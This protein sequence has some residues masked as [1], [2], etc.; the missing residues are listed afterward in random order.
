MY[1]YM[2]EGKAIAEMFGRIAPRYDLANRL[3]SGGV[4]TYW[5]WRMVRL[6]KKIQP[7]RVIDL[8]TGSGDVA[9]ALRK[10][11]GRN[12]NIIGLDFCPEM[13]EQAA[14]KQAHLPDSQKITFT[15]GDCLNPPLPPE[16]AD[17][18]TIA[19]GVRNLEDRKKGFEAMWN[20]LRPGGM[21]VILEAS[22]PYRGFKGLY[23]FYL[24]HLMPRIAR[25]IAQDGSAYDYLADS[26]AAFPTAYELADELRDAGFKNVHTRRLTL[27]IVALHSAIK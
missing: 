3:L 10:G 27:G 23:Y 26:I 16:T 25:L 24:K 5:R 22:Q 4:D 15:L 17:G 8:A 19:F 6:L 9:F 20:L 11:L 7:T 1:R 14:I 13:L 2:P 21:L 12:I 18:L